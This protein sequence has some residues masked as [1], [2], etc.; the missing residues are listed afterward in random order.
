MTGLGVA[1]RLRAR[2]IVLVWLLL[3]LLAAA[4]VRNGEERLLVSWA[5]AAVHP[6]A[7]AV[8]A[9]VTTVDDAGAAG[10]QTIERDLRAYAAEIRPRRPD[11]LAG[12]A[13]LAEAVRDRERAIA[14][15]RRAAALSGAFPSLSEGFR[16]A[17][18]VYRVRGGGVLEIDAGTAD[19]IVRDTPVL[20]PDG[21]VGR[22]IRVG[23]HT[24]WVETIQKANAGVAVLAGEARVPGLAT[25]TGTG[26]LRVEYVSRRAPVVVGDPV[27][28]SGADGIYPPDLPVARVTRVRETPGA[29]LEV[30]ARPVTD[31]AHL[32]LVLLV[33][34]WGSAAGGKGT[35]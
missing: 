8:T 26:V 35:P 10:L 3:E 1:S 17:A 13:A 9:T 28:T 4:Q 12:A 27:V 23:V 22:V 24:S 11:A 15:L 2:T 5:R 20:G 21:V 25:G 30:E 18:C 16:V 32:R 31:F 7:V 34:G 14:L 6:V 29:L 33:P 19:G